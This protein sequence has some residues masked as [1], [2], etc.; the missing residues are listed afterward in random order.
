VLTRAQLRAQRRQRISASLA[1]YG[2]RAAVREMKRQAINA[3]K[4]EY[5][6]QYVIT[7]R[8]ANA[9]PKWAP[10]ANKAVA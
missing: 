10:L 3:A 6:R 9:L 1:D 7:E 5:Q 8:I 4:R 2:E